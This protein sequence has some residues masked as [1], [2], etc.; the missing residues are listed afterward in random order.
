M[1]IGY[2]LQ[3]FLAI[4][5]RAIRATFN[6]QIYQSALKGSLSNR[7][8]HMFLAAIDDLF[9]NHFFLS[10]AFPSDLDQI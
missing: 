1:E 10:S 5:L 9:E 3:G 8:E 6:T 4:P 2:G 7:R